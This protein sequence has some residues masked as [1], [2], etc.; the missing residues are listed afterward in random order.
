VNELHSILDHSDD[1]TA[2][3]AT[4]SDDDKSLSSYN[5]GDNDQ[6]EFFIPVPKAKYTMNYDLVPCSMLIAK[7]IN[8][9]P[10]LCLL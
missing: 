8:N 6:Y 1:V 10:S 3:T 5:E 2:T 7:L 9:T 4:M